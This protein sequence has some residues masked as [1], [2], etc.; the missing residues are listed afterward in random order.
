MKRF[1]SILII[2]FISIYINKCDNLGQ[3][4]Y[5]SGPCKDSWD[6]YYDAKGKFI[7]MNNMNKENDIKI[8]FDD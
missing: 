2:L 3:I 5:F 8:N 1:N 6:E 4:G 7:V